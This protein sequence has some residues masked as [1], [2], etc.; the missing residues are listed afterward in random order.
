MLMGEVAC[1]QARKNAGLV[2]T[3]AVEVFYST[4]GGARL[5][6]SFPAA[7]PYLRRPCLTVHLPCLT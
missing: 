4:P 3:D 6:T 5:S 2:A 1:L 7:A